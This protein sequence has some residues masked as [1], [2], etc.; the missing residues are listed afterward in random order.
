M[1]VQSSCSSTRPRTKGKGEG[2]GQDTHRWTKPSMGEVQRTVNIDANAD[3]NLN[4]NIDENLLANIDANIDEN[5]FANIDAN[6]DVNVDANINF[7]DLRKEVE[8]CDVIESSVREGLY[9]K[10]KRCNVHVDSESQC[11]VH[12]D[13]VSCNPQSLDKEGVSIQTNQPSPEFPKLSAMVPS[14]NIKP[15][16]RMPSHVS[17]DCVSDTCNVREVLCDNIPIVQGRVIPMTPSVSVRK[18]PV[19][20]VLGSRVQRLIEF[21]NSLGSPQNVGGKTIVSSRGGK[22]GNLGGGAG[23]G[24]NGNDPPSGG[25]N[26]IDGDTGRREGANF[27]FGVDVAVASIDRIQTFRANELLVAAVAKPPA[28]GGCRVSH[29]TCTVSIQTERQSAT[30][31]SAGTIRVPMS[32]VTSVHEL[33]N[34]PHSEK[35]DPL[36]HGGGG[37]AGAQNPDG[38]GSGGGGGVGRGNNGK[39][40]SS[41][42]VDGSTESMHDAK[43]VKGPSRPNKQRPTRIQHGGVRL[44]CPHKK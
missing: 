16:P 42:V 12:A 3:V 8:S 22:S 41:P 37:G 32:D 18:E 39:G 21:Y 4:T 11:S 15:V 43:V 9:L 25:G 13:F 1:L 44:G 30:S 29:D 2:A 20:R 36:N 7:V 10:S 26:P 6:I 34:D 14:A 35:A 24:A 17:S 38:A 27:P 5:V 31:V 33:K 19:H 23:G 28:K 40:D